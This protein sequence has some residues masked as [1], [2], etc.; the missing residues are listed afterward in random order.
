M[1]TRRCYEID[2]DDEKYVSR[3]AGLSRESDWKVPSN[4]IDNGEYDSVRDFAENVGS[5][6]GKPSIHS[7]RQFSRFPKHSCFEKLHKTSRNRSTFG[8][9]EFSIGAGRKINM[10]AANIRFLQVNQRIA[11]FPEGESSNNCG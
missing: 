8:I 3:S 10:K 9:I 4:E 5:C 7:T 11:Q 6:K 2:Q 1:V